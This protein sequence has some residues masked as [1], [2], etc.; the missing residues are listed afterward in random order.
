MAYTTINKSI[1]Y[2]D[3]KLWTGNNTDPTTISGLNFQP[4]MVWAKARS[5]SYET[6]DHCMNDAVRGANKILRVNQTSQEETDDN[7]L[8][9]FTSDGW[10]M[11]NDG[12][13]NQASTTYVGWAWKA[14]TGQGSSNTDGSINTT[15]TSVNTTAGFSISTYTGTGANATIGHGLGAVPAVYILRRLNGANGTWLMYHQSLGIGYHMG[16]NNTTGQNTNDATYANNTAPTNQVVTVGTWGDV[17][18]NGSNFVMYAFAEKTGYSKFGSYKGNGSVD[19][20]FIYTGF[21][22]A[23]LILKRSSASGNNWIMY[24]N[25][26][27]VDN[28]AHHRLHADISNS[29]VNTSSDTVNNIDFLSNGIKIRN[30]GEAWNHSGSTFIYMAFAE[31]PLVGSNN[32]P[33]TAR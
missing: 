2:F 29:E 15:Y 20:T 30:S 16:L 14:G 8:K 6:Q 13:I 22:P 10:T 3:T 31:V 18:A 17:N 33:S 21:K 32:V 7:N 12:K 25:K 9:S 19:G 26:R 4:D 27:D 23:F 5:G 28:V 11:G 1:D 24:D